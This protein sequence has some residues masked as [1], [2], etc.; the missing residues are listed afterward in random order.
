MKYKAKKSYFEL[1][2]A[3]NFNGHFSSAK[4]NKLINGESV[5]ITSVP[6]GLVKH[7]ES[8]EPKKSVKK[9]DK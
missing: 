1:S 2:D 5:E 4:H 3:D 7:L 8:A 9:E 6:E